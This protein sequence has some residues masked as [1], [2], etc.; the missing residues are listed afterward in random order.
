MCCGQLA[1]KSESFANYQVSI[2]KFYPGFWVWA[3]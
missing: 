1:Y 3:W 2:I